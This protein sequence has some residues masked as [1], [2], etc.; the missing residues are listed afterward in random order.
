MAYLNEIEARD[1]TFF[2]KNDYSVVCQRLRPELE[3]LKENSDSYNKIVKFLVIAEDHRFYKHP[4]FD[5]IGICRAIYRDVF[6]GKRE[7]ASTI[8]QQLVRVLTEDYR[9]SSRR[10]IKEIYLATKLK[11]FADKYTLA[12]AYLDMA[13]YGTDYAGL[14]AILLKFGASLGSDLDDDICAEVVAR[15]KYPEPRRYNAVRMAQIAMRKNHIL[16][17]YKEKYECR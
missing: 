15:L 4:G 7:G 17:L 1:E 9:Y 11:R 16:R 5:V 10:K 12:A 14:S 2:Y 13:N 3:K 8:E 6:K